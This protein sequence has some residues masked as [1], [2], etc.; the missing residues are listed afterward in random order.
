M[1]ND[2]I[3]YIDLVEVLHE[4]P[5]NASFHLP[6][7]VG[8][9]I[10]IMKTLGN[11]RED[12]DMNCVNHNA[13]EQICWKR[14][15]VDMLNRYSNIFGISMAELLKSGLTDVNVFYDELCEAIKNADAILPRVK[16]K[17]TCKAFL[18]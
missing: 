1:D 4:H 15:S 8:L 3:K 18:E 12:D 5:D 11:G 13:N 17:K 14:C 16:Y 10:E 7:T 6:L 9:C 2:L